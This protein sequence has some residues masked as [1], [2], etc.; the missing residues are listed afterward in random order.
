MRNRFYTVLNSVS[1]KVI[2]LI[3]VLVLPLNLIAIIA[4]NST[5]NTVVERTIL[6]EQD[7]A[8]SYMSDI[9]LRMDN[10]QSLLHYFS[11]KDSDFIQMKMQREDNYDYQSAK[12]KSYY[13]LETIAGMIDGGDGFY[14]YNKYVDDIMVSSENTGHSSVI[15]HIKKYAESW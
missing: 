15:N 13:H 6:M 12:L 10:T 9:S 3:I 11:S 8:N 5:L 7:F 2:L 4:V 1:T 14:F